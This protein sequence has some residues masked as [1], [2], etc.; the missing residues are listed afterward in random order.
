M[1][2]HTESLYQLISSTLIAP[3]KFTR[4]DFKDSH[5]KEEAIHIEEETITETVPTWQPPSER[6]P[7]REELA[8]ITTMV[9]NRKYLVSTEN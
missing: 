9:S 7:K 6:V 3:L 1:V 2:E 8:R 4:C 5:H